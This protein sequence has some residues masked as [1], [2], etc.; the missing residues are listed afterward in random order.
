MARLLIIVALLVALFAV[1]VFAM[2]AI[3]GAAQ[4]GHRT[5]RAIAQE[6]NLQKISYVALLVLLFGVASGWLGGL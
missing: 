6:S 2:N 4:T 3:A 5:G 1:M